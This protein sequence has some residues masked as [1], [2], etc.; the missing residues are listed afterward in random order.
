MSFVILSAAKDL[1]CNNEQSLRCR[2]GTQSLSEAAEI[3]GFYGRGMLKLS[4]RLTRGSI[5]G[6]RANKPART[7]RQARSC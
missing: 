7:R 5:S 1:I 3:F 4:L 2:P 6:C